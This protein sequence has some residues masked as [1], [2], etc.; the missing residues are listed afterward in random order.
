[1]ASRLDE[2]VEREGNN[3]IICIFEMVMVD[4]AGTRELFSVSLGVTSHR[5]IIVGV[6]E[7]T[8]T[9]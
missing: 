8:V 4:T 1:M 3:I 2:E 7:V 6:I 9:L 5:P